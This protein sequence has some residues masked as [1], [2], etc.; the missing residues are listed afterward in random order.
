V[1]CH[2]A[3]ARVSSLHGIVAGH[4][5]ASYRRVSRPSP[6]PSSRETGAEIRACFASFART[7]VFPC[8]EKSNEIF[9][10]D[11]NGAGNETSAALSLSL[12]LSFYLGVSP[13]LLLSCV[14]V[15]RS[16]TSAYSIAPLCSGFSNSASL[17]VINWQ[18]PAWSLLDHFVV[19]ASN[20][21]TPVLS[22]L[23]PFVGRRGDA[24]V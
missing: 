7:A 3:R 12:S 17:R 6:P 23:A 14:L 13:F 16:L 2:C 15:P 10:A 1:C 8:R 5:S 18:S 4:A 9:R 20:H 11:C 22:S 19:A 24:S 21:R